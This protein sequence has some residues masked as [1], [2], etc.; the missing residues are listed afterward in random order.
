MM[1][2][3]HRQSTFTN[4]H[5]LEVLPPKYD[6]A[7]FALSI[8]EILSLSARQFSGPKGYSPEIAPPHLG[9]TQLPN[10]EKSARV[11]IRFYDQ[12]IEVG[13]GKNDEH[14]TMSHTSPDIVK[15]KWRWEQIANQRNQYEKKTDKKNFS[16]FPWKSDMPMP[17]KCDHSKEPSVP[18]C[19]QNPR[20]AVWNGWLYMKASG[21]TNLIKQPKRLWSVLHVENMQL[22]LECYNKDSA[23]TLLLDPARK[24]RREMTGLACGGRA[25]VS[26][27]ER[28][29]GRWYSAACDSPE[30][31]DGLV[32]RINTLLASLRACAV[33][34]KEMN[35]E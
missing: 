30:D 1:L 25:R 3:A 34:G 11:K 13:F 28:G 26:M 6:D 18:D 12:E 32:C 10:V 20:D 2:T 15:Q 17:F 9:K 29:T 16:L 5:V 21:M 31:A 14:Q 22:K 27:A 4:Q 7:I 24:A 33:D 8:Q 23:T 35:C 19:N